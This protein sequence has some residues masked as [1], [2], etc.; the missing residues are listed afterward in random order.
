M[1]V[2]CK[3]APEAVPPAPRR[4]RF[5]AL[6][7]MSVAFMLAFADATDGTTLENRQDRS[8]EQTIK[9]HRPAGCVREHG[10]CFRISQPDA[11]EFQALSQ[12]ADDGNRC[13]TLRALRGG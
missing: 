6:E 11:M 5:I 13:F 1:Q 8:P 12:T 9:I 3:S 7:V 2:R 10:A 4:Q